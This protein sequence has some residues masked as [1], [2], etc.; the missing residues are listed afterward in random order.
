ML[1]QLAQ[2]R[3]QAHA[4]RQ[5]MLDD[6]LAKKE[7]LEIEAPVRRSPPVQPKTPPKQPP[8]NPPAHVVRAHFEACRLAEL[9]RKRVAFALETAPWRTREHVAEQQEQEPA[10]ADVSADEAG[11]VAEM[12]VDRSSSDEEGTFVEEQEVAVADEAAG[13]SGCVAKQPPLTIHDQSADDACVAKQQAATAA[14]QKELGKHA[15]ARATHAGFRM[16]YELQLRR[17][18]RQHT[19][20]TG[21]ISPGSSSTGPEMQHAPNTGAI[22]PGSSSRPASEGLPRPEFS[23]ARLEYYRI[24]EARRADERSTAESDA[25]AMRLRV[26]VEQLEAGHQY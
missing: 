25:L 11:C 14:E 24:L 18:V 26:L 22:S 8:G 23:A 13:E 17:A 20:N 5:A 3:Q 6:A 10:V 4:E 16:A 7:A 19:P 15:V 2:M 12:A 1:D 21:A 9:S